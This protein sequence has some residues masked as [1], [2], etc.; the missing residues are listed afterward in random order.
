[1]IIIA[2]VALS[3]GALMTTAA[4]AGYWQ[5]VMS[6]GAFTTMTL[7]GVLLV[8]GALI[9]AGN[10]GSGIALAAVGLVL[11]SDAA[12]AVGSRRENG[13]RLTHHVIRAGIGVL[14]LAGMLLAR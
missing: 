13:P 2:A 6:R 5:R 12:Y 4:S 3:Y 11:I 10:S 14:I 8:L 9:Y 7:G 1:M